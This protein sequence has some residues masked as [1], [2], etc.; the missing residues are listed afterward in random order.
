VGYSNDEGRV[1]P[2][3]LS[4]RTPIGH[5]FAGRHRPVSPD[6]PL[7]VIVFTFAAL[8]WT[9]EFSLFGVNIVSLQ[10]PSFFTPEWSVRW[11]GS[12]IAWIIYFPSECRPLFSVG[13]LQPS[14]FSHI[15]FCCLS[16]SC[17]FSL[18]HPLTLLGSLFLKGISLHR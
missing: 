1:H 18:Y 13:S 7:P 2:P 8:R 17:R 15:R 10:S 12:F 6:F 9:F 14:L 5:G 16:L 3:F 4:I 11:L